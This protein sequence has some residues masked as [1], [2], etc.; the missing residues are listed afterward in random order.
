MGSILVAQM[1]DGCSFE[2]LKLS[3][4]KKNWKRKPLYSSNRKIKPLGWE[5]QESKV[6]AIL[7]WRDNQSI[8]YNS[9]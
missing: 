1:Y 5:M 3:T 2:I 7:T 8:M 6:D 9:Y 4:P